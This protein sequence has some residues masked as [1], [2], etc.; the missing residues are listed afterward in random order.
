MERP[1]SSDFSMFWMP[2]EDPVF[3]GDQV[4]ADNYGTGRHD[5][6]GLFTISS[7][8]ETP[9]HVLV[10]LCVANNPQKA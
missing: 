6:F 8:I 3:S 4:P 7:N 10:F 9:P 1:E 5:E 2:V